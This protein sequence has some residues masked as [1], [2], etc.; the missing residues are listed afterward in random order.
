MLEIHAEVA[1]RRYPCQIGRRPRR[2]R[3][4]RVSRAI[5]GRIVTD[6]GFAVGGQMHIELEAIRARGET[7]VECRH[8]VF[9]RQRAAAA[10]RE[11]ERAAVSALSW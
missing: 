3:T 7:G 4:R 6:D 1:G 2:D 8:G 10:V 5:E 11:D 9:G